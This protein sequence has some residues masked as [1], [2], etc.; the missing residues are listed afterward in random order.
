MALGRFSIGIVS[1]VALGLM[2]TYCS[3]VAPSVSKDSILGDRRASLLPGPKATPALARFRVVSK[4]V[5][6]ESLVKELKSLGISEKD[7]YRLGAEEVQT[8][9]ARGSLEIESPW[10]GVH[11]SQIV[12]YFRPETAALGELIFESFLEG[13]M[14]SP[15]KVI[16]LALH[17]DSEFPAERDEADPSRILPR[18]GPLSEIV[19]VQ[20]KRA[21]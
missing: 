3:P 12:A 11:A 21:N 18:P 2:L 17:E 16:H 14:D 20:L 1:A 4:T 7:Q 13:A 9:L 5:T 8:L 15:N 10:P 6:E 19:I